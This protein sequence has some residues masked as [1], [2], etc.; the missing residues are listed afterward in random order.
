VNHHPNKVECFDV[1]D[2]H[3]FKKHILGNRT[4]LYL[5]VIRKIKRLLK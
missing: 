5:R 2:K 3:H 4:P 1:Y